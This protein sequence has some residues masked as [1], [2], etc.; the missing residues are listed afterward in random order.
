[1]VSRLSVLILCAALAA[2]LAP[3]EAEA[4]SLLGG[5][6]LSPGEGAVDVQVGYPA[7][8]FGYHMPIT[9]SLE[10]IPQFALFWGSLDAYGIFPSVPA[11][12]AFGLRPG[13]TIRLKIYSKGTVHIAAQWLI[14]VPL[15][16]TPGFFVAFQFGAPGGVAVTWEAH[17]I[18]NLVAGFQAS[19]GVSLDSNPVFSIP[20]IFRVGGEVEVAKNINLTAQFEGGPVIAVVSSGNRNFTSANGYV[21]GLFGVQYKH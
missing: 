21:G 8:R 1:M 17:K 10:I 12:S 18:F 15:A 7:L 9:D 20:L 16:L 14:G 4:Y 5:K 6:L 19:F 2:T 3:R 11:G 13:G